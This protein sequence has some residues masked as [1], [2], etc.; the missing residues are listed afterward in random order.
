MTSPTPTTV[1][2]GKFE[3][4][5]SK[6]LLE[7][8][9]TNGI[10]F[11]IAADHSELLRPGRTVEMILGTFPD[12]SKLAV[13]VKERD[14]AAAQ[15]VMKKVFPEFQAVVPPPMAYKPEGAPTVSPYLVV[16][17]AENTLTFLRSVF[18]AE[19][20]Q[21]V[22]GDGD[23]T[24]HAEVRIE[25]SVIMLADA[26]PTWPALPAHVHIYVSDVDETYRRALEA[27]ATSV[28][29]PVKKEDTDKRGGV[30]DAGG[31]TWWIATQV[32]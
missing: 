25:D 32:G 6:R 29:A 2:L 7:A 4:A 16:N 10:A 23:R 9:E 15:N 14:L 20:V 18:G 5:D 17:G 27:G 26:T 22:R 31:T 1:L 12:G 19:V 24:L 30:K 21:Q 13:F 11:E 8:L 3:P 28:Q